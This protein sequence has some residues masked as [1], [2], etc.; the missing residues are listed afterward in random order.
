MEYFS[1]LNADRKNE[2]TNGK[3]SYWEAGFSSDAMFTP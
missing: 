2:V 3:V 1:F